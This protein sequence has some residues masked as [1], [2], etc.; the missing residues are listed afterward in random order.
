MKLHK[1]KS[2]NL[3]CSYIFFAVSSASS[4]ESVTQ[5]NIINSRNSSINRWKPS[6]QYTN[7]YHNR[8][9][10]VTPVASPASSRS[11]SRRKITSSAE[12]TRRI[13]RVCSKEKLQQ[14]SHGSSSEDLSVRDAG[15][16]PRPRPRRTKNIKEREKNDSIRT[17][18]S[19]DSKNSSLTQNNCKNIFERLSSAKS[20]SRG[21]WQC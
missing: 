17:S 19:N 1:A 14:Q 10:N 21:E 7:G 9:H 6:S 18:K 4:S 15:D 16:A 11:S 12:T 3:C 13:H 20:S 8:N 2:L 5:T